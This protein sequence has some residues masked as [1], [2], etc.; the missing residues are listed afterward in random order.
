MIM[1]IQAS[2]NNPHELVRY[3][4]HKPLNSATYKPTVHAIDRGPIHTIHIP[5]QH[6][7]Y[8]Y[9]YP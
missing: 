3:I 9:T 7:N 1:I 5:H 4:Y 6:S 8:R 2:H